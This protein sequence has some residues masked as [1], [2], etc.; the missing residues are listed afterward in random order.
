MPFDLSESW[1]LDLENQ[2]GAR[3]P[4]AYRIAMLVDNGG[5]LSLLN[6]KALD[7]SWWLYPIEDRTDRKRLSRSA[8][9]VLKETLSCRAWESF[10]ANGLAIADNGSAD[11]LLFL[12]GDAQF[13]S[14]V[15][16]WNHETGLVTVMAPDFSHFK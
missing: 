14:T 9:Y 3:L 16:H 6:G 7:D 2:L 10:P 12:L 1:V 11:Q 13:D 4:E 15:Y 5:A 8:N